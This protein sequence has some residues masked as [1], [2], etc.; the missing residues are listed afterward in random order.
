LAAKWNRAWKSPWNRTV[1]RAF[2][3]RFGSKLADLGFGYP[4]S[5]SFGR[6]GLLL[7]VK[8]R[9]SK[10]EPKSAIDPEQKLK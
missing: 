4:N 7:N 9:C 10:I 5:K 1:S 3:F 8:R 2:E 6:D